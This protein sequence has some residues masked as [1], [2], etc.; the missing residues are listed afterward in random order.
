MK[1]K[2]IIFFFSNNWFFRFLYIKVEDFKNEAKCESSKFIAD[3]GRIYIGFSRNISHAKMM[4]KFSIVSIGKDG[5]RKQIKYQKKL[6]AVDKYYTDNKILKSDTLI[7]KGNENKVQKLYDFRNIT[8]RI[9]AGKN[10]GNYYCSLIYKDNFHNEGH[11]Q[12]NS[13]SINYISIDLN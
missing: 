9:R 2:K 13:T 7:I 6:D 3:G 11:Y 10:R 4:R 12:D 1:M 8:T 5:K